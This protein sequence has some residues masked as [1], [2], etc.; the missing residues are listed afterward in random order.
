MP[1]KKQGFTLIELL[2]VIAIIGILAA[3][4]LPALGRVQEKTIRVEVKTT[5][6]NLESSLKMYEADEGDFPPSENEGNSDG[7]TNPHFDGA[8]VRFLDGNNSND[9]NVNGKPNQY[10]E[11]PPD[12]VFDG[13]DA[14]HPIFASRFETPFF[15]KNMQA[16]GRFNPDKDNDPDPRVAIVK[17]KTF[18]VYNQLGD[19]VKE[20]PETW[21][22]NYR[23]P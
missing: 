22:T 5:I 3:V 17:F 18:Q 6:T 20:E 19:V 8:L 4:L 9:D 7:G 23:S 2:V 21:I 13:K 14:K 1:Q 16:L 12:D 11:F 10:F 15:Y